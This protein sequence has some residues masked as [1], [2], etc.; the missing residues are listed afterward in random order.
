MRTCVIAVVLV[1]GSGACR[2][3]AP[4][5]GAE[6]HG[7]EHATEQADLPGKTVTTWTA[8]SELFME[9]PALVVGQ[10]TAFAAHLTVLTGWQPLSKGKVTLTLKMAD[11][12]AM[13]AEVTAPSRPGIYRPTL[14]PAT[15]GTCTLSVTIDG[16]HADQ[17]DAGSCEVYPDAKAAGA[18]SPKEDKGGGISFLKEQQWVTDFTSTPAVERELT[19]TVRVNGQIKAVAGKEARLAAAAPGRVQFTM[20]APVIGMSVRKGQL[21][22][23]LLPRL[24][25]G[26]DRAS[27]EAEVQ[28]ARAEAVAAEAQLGRAERLFA[29]Q[30]VPRR[31]VEEA[32]AAAEVAR[33]RTTAAQGRL[34]QQSATARGMG[35][36]GRGAFQVR[37]PTG[38]TLAA[39]QIASG[40]SVE[41]GQGL[42]VVVDLA[43]VWLEGRVFEPD[44]PKVEGAR[45]G[46]FWLEGYEAPFEFDG[47][48][49]RLITLGRVLDPQSRTV[50]LIFEL[51]NTDGKLRIGQ[52]AK[53]DVAAGPPT[54]TLA[55]PV[56]AVVEESAKPIVY[57]QV[58]GEGFERRPLTLGSRSGGWIAVRDGI[59]AG[60]RVVTRGAYEVKLVSSAGATP[61]S[62]HAH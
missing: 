18:A 53:M 19:P 20:P 30:S 48:S 14:K 6:G 54:R 35:G 58:S 41:E 37:S 50:P 44:I 12:R 28:A 21:L 8:K 40:E 42:F 17:I 15:P 9:H 31:S 29:D 11:G 51:D 59:R 34:A 47:K 60:E 38:G 13:H 62:G 5:G 22:A 55:I 10:E 45:A 27:L 25:G 2:R 57:V 36:A 52:F 56:S 46:W 1:M 4:G 24:S 43:K 7:H 3:S 33:A 32:R 49:A 61:A 23:A 16:D 39:V 26:T